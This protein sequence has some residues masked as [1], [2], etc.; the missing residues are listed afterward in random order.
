VKLLKPKV[1]SCGRIH[2]E[3]PAGVRLFEDGDL[4]GY[5]WNCACHSTLFVGPE[6]IALEE[7]A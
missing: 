6:G 2:L 3:V 1:C 7:V 4:S 5:F